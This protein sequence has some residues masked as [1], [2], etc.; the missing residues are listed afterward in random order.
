MN[1]VVRFETKWKYSN[2]GGRV[3]PVEENSR[4]RRTKPV[5]DGFFSYTR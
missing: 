5:F 1:K 2:I 3:P 4:S